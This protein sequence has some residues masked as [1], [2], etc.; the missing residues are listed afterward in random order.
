MWRLV[1]WKDVSERGMRTFA[2]TLVG[3]FTVAGN[4]VGF[5]DV[6]WTRGLSISGM[7]TL[8]TVLMAIATHGVTGNGPSF[9]SVYKGKDKGNG[10]GD[11]GSERESA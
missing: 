8:A 10:N 4:V 11:P 6:A 1:W 7:A 3:W 2:A 9:T 5:E